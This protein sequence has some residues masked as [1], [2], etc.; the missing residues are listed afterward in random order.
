MKNKYKITG[1][2]RL[3]IFLILLTPIAYIGANYY[4]GEDGIEKIKILLGRTQDIDTE[5]SK[6]KQEIK[7]LEEKLQKSKEELSKLENKE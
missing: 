7:K 1:F 2:T 6:K 4:Q 3:L 5:I